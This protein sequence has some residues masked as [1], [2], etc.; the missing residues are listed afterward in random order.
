MPQAVIEINGVAGSDADLPIGTLVQLSNA[1][2]GGEITYLWEIV[3]QPEGTADAL[4]SSAIEN[5]T[6]TPN[7]EGS[8]MLRLTVNASLSTEHVDQ[9]IAA[10]LSIKTSERIPAA[11]E[12]TEVDAAAGWKASV[13]ALLTRLNNTLA[14]A[15]IIVCKLPGASVPALGDIVTI[16]KT[17]AVLKTGLPGEEVIPACAKC[18][19]SSAVSIIGPLGSVIGAPDGGALVANGYACVR[20]FGI[21]EVAEAGAPT[22]GDLVYVSDLAQPALVAGSNSRIIGSVTYSSAGV[23]RWLVTGFK[24][25]S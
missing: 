7:K 19:A 1:D 2:I 23:W 12:T 17:D 11:T 5:P 18:L 4:S 25:P 24:V 10:V 3:D 20:M 8:Y 16:G 21:S 22:A 15:N 14:D 9:A 13:N 6:F